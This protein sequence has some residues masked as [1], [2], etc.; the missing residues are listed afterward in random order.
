[1]SVNKL[2][3]SE[4][5][6]ETESS[7]TYRVT[8]Y[9][10]DSEELREFIRENY[11][12][13]GET[14]EYGLIKRTSFREEEGI[15]YC[16]VEGE[17]DIDGFGYVYIKHIEEGPYRQSL[18]THCISMPLERHAN[19]RTIWDHYVWVQVPADGS[20]G[21]TWEYKDKKTD[22]PFYDMNGRRYA[23]TKNCNAYELPD[24]D[25]ADHT[26]RFLDSPSKPGLSHFEFFTYTI[27][28]MGEHSTAE[29]AYWVIQ[30]NLNTP[31]QKPILGSMGITGGE[32]KC[33]SASIEPNGKRWY[34][35][36][37]WTWS[38][39]GWDHDLYPVTLA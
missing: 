30:Q 36:L 18:Q 22:T 31:K 16:D 35:R 24:P 13:N 5:R 7:I 14:E 34:T 19:Y 25:P 23:W 32:W 4:K 15:F 29:S 38:P 27:T 10:S 8:F 26:W 21:H 9:S 6:E 39:G 12:Q 11:P 33:D 28:E 1:M 37:V 2:F 20:F 17:H 3:N